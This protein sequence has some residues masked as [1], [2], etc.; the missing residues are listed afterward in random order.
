MDSEEIEGGDNNKVKAETTIRTFSSHAAA[1]LAVA[2]LQAHGI[3]CRIYADDAGG[4]LPNLTAPG[5]VRLSVRNAD[6]TAAAALL[7]KPPSALQ[8][9]SKPVID[10]GGTVKPYQKPPPPPP[11]PLEPE[12]RKSVVPGELVIGVILGVLLCLLYQWGRDLGTKTR[13]YYKDGVKYEALVNNNGQP[14]QVMKDRNLD[15]IWD[16]WTYYENGR[17]VRVENDNN[18]D[19]KPDEILT[20]SDGALVKMAKDTDFNGTPDEFCTYK[21]GL[22]QQVDFRPNGAK[23]PTRRE[24]FQNGVLSEVFL[25]P[26]T[27]GRFTELVK[28]D[29]FSNP[30]STNK[31]P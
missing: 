31:V 29:P 3:P 2:N 23:F 14:V 10:V 16:Q 17:I 26:D 20:Y 27:N 5:G 7:D 18:F 1:D 11:Y 22:P 30:I 9:A 25:E 19:G 13:Y 12:T 4:M 21:D 24:L 28:Y 8:L 6:A 15:G